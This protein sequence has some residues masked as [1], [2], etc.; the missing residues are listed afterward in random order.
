[1]KKSY[2]YS[3]ANEYKQKIV[4]QYINLEIDGWMTFLSALIGGATSTLILGKLLHPL[5]GQVGFMI[6]TGI[7]FCVVFIMANALANIN[8]DTGKNKIEEFYYIHFKKYRYIYNQDGCKLYI[9]K[10]KKGEIFINAC[11]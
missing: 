1:M 6:G 9:Q 11:R 2:N 4:I 5:F 3:I 8:S 10:K 7:S